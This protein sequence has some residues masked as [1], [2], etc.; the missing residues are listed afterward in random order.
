M[1]SNMQLFSKANQLVDLTLS[2]KLSR[3][4]GFVNNEIKM[5]FES[6]FLGEYLNVS[7][8]M[9]KL[10][11]K[12]NGYSWD[13]NIRERTSFLAKLIRL[14]HIKDIA[15]H[16]IRINRDC[17]IPVIEIVNKET[18]YLILEIPNSEMRDSLIASI[19]YFESQH[20]E[21]YEGYYHLHIY[22]LILYIGLSFRNEDA[23]SEDK[24]NSNQVIMSLIKGAIDQVFETK[25]YNDHTDPE[26]YNKMRYAIG[27]VY[28]T[29]T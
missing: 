6:K 20:A 7:E 11:E 4:Y 26:S 14:E 18:E 23:T 17:I 29:G 25:Y 2:D 9:N 13:G 27:C 28:S 16:E 15:K 19:P 3:A 24:N 12:Y 5:T 22:M 8:T 1:F 10:K 21:K